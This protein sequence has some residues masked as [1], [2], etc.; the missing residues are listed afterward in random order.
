MRVARIASILALFAP[1]LSVSNAFAAPQNSRARKNRRAPATRLSALLPAG[2]HAKGSNV[3]LAG[4]LF[5][6]LSKF[7]IGPAKAK[8][9]AANV[10]TAVDIGDLVFISMLGWALPPLA[11][12][13][14]NR[15][16]GESASDYDF[17][18][19]KT[20]KGSILVSQ[21]AKVAAIVYIVDVLAIALD[22]IGVKFL[23]ELN[24]AS[25]CAEL[26]Y[27]L[28]A[29]WRFIPFKRYLI[30]KQLKAKSP[31]DLGKVKLLD[32]LADILIAVTTT[33][34]ILDELRVPTGRALQS[35]F[36]LGGVGTLVFS[37]ASKD[38]AAQFVSGLAL[39]TSNKF[40]EG[41]IVL[42]GDGTQ[43]IVAKMGWM[44]TDLRGMS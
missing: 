44:S 36:A 1:Q 18:M 17:K 20:F 7:F 26:L 38:V 37:L 28:Y 19:T 33:F 10:G 24:F 40:D 41:D 2:K 8:K 23:Y 14:Y 22:A 32:R 34:V 16:I 30:E 11:R 27:T 4:Q 35:V 3:A 15:R 25:K 29:A 43:G 12:L 31:E 9:I 13:V 5:P 6:I 21:L 42:L 39:S